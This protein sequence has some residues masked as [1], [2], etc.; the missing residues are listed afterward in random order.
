[1]KTTFNIKNISIIALLFLL[2]GAVYTAKA[3]AAPPKRAEITLS[4]LPDNDEDEECGDDDLDGVDGPY[5][6]GEY[7]YRV[8]A[9]D[10]LIKEKINRSNPVWVEVKNKDKDRF[11]LHLKS[12]IKP[13]PSTLP[14]PK[15]L[16]AISDIEGNFD[17]F[18]SFLQSNGVIDKEF[19]WSFGDGHLVL[20]GD[21]VDRGDNVTA[22]LWL[23][24]KLEGEAE[25]AGGAVHMILGNHELMNMQ[26]KH[27]YN[28]ERYVCAA[29]KISGQEDSRKAVKY[30]YSK[31][32]LGHWLQSRN[33]VMKIGTTLFVHAGLS[34]EILEHNLSIEEINRISRENLTKDLYRRPG[35]DAKA[36]FLLGAK[37][38]FWYRGF[39]SSHK[40]IYKKIE[41]H[42]LDEILSRYGAERVVFGHS[43]VKEI[44]PTF[45][46]KA[47]NIDLKHGTE[48]RSGKT[49]GI[50]IEDGTFYRIDDLGK[51]ENLY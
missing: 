1:M 19:G 39:A 15:K 36:N 27:Q 50:L 23:I 37:G 41:Q 38:I 9:K 11:S 46:G 31:T 24:Y 5:I 21:F 17:G 42:E 4:T 29:Q 12:D 30:I 49:K 40:E 2:F 7:L 26:G 34:P 10:K 20:V 44:V 51:R 25:K 3:D 35:E 48:K 47:I 8:N 16:I 28:R 6:I 13:S 22:V 43:V 14:M 18:A 33:G 45:N 32:E